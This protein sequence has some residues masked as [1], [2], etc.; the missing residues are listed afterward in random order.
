MQETD[1]IIHVERIVKEVHDTTEKYTLP[2][3]K[4]YPLTFSF[5]TIFSV[6]AILHGFEL[7]TDKFL[8]FREYPSVL[9]F[10]G[11]LSLLLTGALYKT[12]EKMR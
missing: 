12:L 2:V 6:A 8:F 5:L 7:F 4:R 1:P 10:A 3:L 11:I 9:I